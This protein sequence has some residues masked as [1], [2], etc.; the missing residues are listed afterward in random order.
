LAKAALL[1]V[2]V[3][4]DF[5]PGGALA[6]P[7]GDSIVPKL[8][9]VIS[10]FEKAGLP[11]FFTRDWHPANH[12]S[13]REQGGV[14]PRHCVQGTKG[15]EIHGGLKQPPASVV[16]SKGDRPD[17]EAY[18]GFQGTDLAERLR[19]LGVDQ[20]F[21]GGLT[22]EYC[23]RTTT[24]DAL[25]EGLAVRVVLACVKGLEIHRGDSAAAIAEMKK[26][27]ASFTEASKV[28]RQL[29]GRN[30]RDEG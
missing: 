23:V 9:T 20:V 28:N 24:E 19:R 17:R 27:G 16:I 1:V 5:C 10:A 7:E 18:S 4:N 26:A 2:D 15:A 13:F 14:W 25:R 6:V 11:V 3:Q 29:V 21:V 22:T 8:N 12:C 30:S